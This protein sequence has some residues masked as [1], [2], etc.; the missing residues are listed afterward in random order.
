[1]DWV[2]IR[3]AG[4][5]RVVPKGSQKLRYVPQYPGTYV[6]ETRRL[7]IGIAQALGEVEVAAFLNCNSDDPTQQTGPNGPLRE[8][9]LGICLDSCARVVALWV[10]TRL[11]QSDG[12]L[13]LTICPQQI[14]WSRPFARPAKRLHDGQ[15]ERE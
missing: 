9:L 10:V 8:K 6:D 14:H 1:M 13:T 4:Y 12:N 11:R 3:N 7:D 2:A 5:A 15:R